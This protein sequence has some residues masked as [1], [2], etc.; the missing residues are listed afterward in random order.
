MLE[1]KSLTKE[2]QS[3]IQ[4]LD[5][6][7]STLEEYKEAIIKLCGAFGGVIED[8]LEHYAEECGAWKLAQEK[9]KDGGMDEC[10]IFLCQASYRAQDKAKNVAV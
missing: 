7:E 6:A 10:D 2:Q 5:I 9:L 3:L 1:Y 8:M 4:E